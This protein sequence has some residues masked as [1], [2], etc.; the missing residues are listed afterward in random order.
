VTQFKWS[1][2]GEPFMARGLS[3]TIRPWSRLSIPVMGGDEPATE[4][5]EPTTKA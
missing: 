1:M 4:D 5:P 3:G 2:S